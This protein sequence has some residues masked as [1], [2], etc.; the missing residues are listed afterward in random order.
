MKIELGFGTGVQEVVLPEKNVLAVLEANPVSF[1]LTGEAE[2]R[3][4]LKHPIGSA[5]LGEIVKPG[6]KIA[7]VTSDITRPCPTAKLL[8]PVLEE[9]FAAGIRPE[10]VTVTFALGSHR[11]HTEEERKKLM[12]EAY[13]LVACR[14]SDSEHCTLLGT[15]SRGTPVEI[16]SAVAGADRRICF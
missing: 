15:T 13:G 12:G 1:D 11:C 2:V 10:D 7:I 4:A 3:R 5:P 16:D 8:P 9:L 6:E 14:D